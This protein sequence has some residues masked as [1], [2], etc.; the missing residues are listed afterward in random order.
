MFPHFQAMNVP[1][2][3]FGLVRAEREFGQNVP[4]TRATDS[5]RN[6][7]VVQNVLIAWK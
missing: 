3:I 7:L 6:D 5:L 1:D 2:P 4:V